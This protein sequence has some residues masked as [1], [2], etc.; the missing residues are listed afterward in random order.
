MKKTLLAVMAAIA[1][2]GGL[3]GCGS[4]SQPAGSPATHAQAPVAVQQLPSA[5]DIAAQ[6][7]GTRFADKN[8]KAN[9]WGMTSAGTFWIGNQKYAVNVFN[10]KELRDA[11]LKVSKQFGVNPKWMTDTSVVYPSLLGGS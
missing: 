6:L 9:L 10:S 4:A 7:H 11:W 8:I 5:R 3:A 1:L 2:M